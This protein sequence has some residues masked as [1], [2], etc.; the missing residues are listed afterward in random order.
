MDILGSLEETNYADIKSFFDSA[1]ILKNA[2][3]I[4]RQLQEFLARNF[5]SSSNNQGL[6]KVAC[7]TSGG[8]T[9]PLEQQCVRYIDNFA[10]GHRGAAATEY[11]LKAG[12]SVVFLHR[13]GTC[14]PYCQSLPYDQLLEC[15]EVDGDSNVRVNPTYAKTIDKAVSANCTAINQGT[16][17]KIP[18]TT[19]FEYL[20]IL[21]LIA[22]S[23]RRFGPRALFFLAAAV[24]DFYVP[25]G[26]MAVHKI[27]SRSGPLDLRLVEVPKM[28]SILRKEWAPLAF[29]ISF[30]LET[31]TKILLEKA[32]MALEKYDMHMV[33]ANELSSYKERVIIVTK[34]GNINVS[35]DMARPDADVEDPL[36]ELVVEKYLAYASSTS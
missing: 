21:Q 8:T 22:L 24:S 11:F 32:G 4:N 25:P 34:N 36:I 12:F 19:I 28:L 5:S 29:C 14:Q 27:Q 2:A 10:S 7:V 23:L 26:S 16:L 3:E 15:F 17:L 35:R 6:R 31:D 30:K 18:F 9:V 20:Q 33:V 1:P 13:R